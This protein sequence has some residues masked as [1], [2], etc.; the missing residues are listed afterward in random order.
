VTTVLNQD[1]DEEGQI[2][3]QGVANKGGDRGHNPLLFNFDHYSANDKELTPRSNWQSKVYRLDALLEQEK[4]KLHKIEFD[5]S[6]TKS[7]LDREI[8]A[9][10]SKLN[11]ETTTNRNIQERL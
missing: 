9:L 4:E 10:G 5:Y 2:N 7:Q 8:T 6:Q 1:S 11:E 3:R